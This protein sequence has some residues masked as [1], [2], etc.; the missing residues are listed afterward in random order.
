ML[1]KVKVREVLI[2][3]IVIEAEDEEMASIDWIGCFGDADFDEIIAECT[4]M[5]EVEEND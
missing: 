1:F 5:L 3:E 4:E 2:H